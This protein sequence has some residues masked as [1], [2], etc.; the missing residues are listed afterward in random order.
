[1]KPKMNNPKHGVVL[2]ALILAVIATL[3][4]VLLPSS[5]N[6]TVSYFFCLIGIALMAG[7]FLVATAK[8]VVASFALIRQ[9][10]R[11][12]PLSLIIAAIVLVLERIKLFT[13]PAIVHVVIQV[14]LL[15]VSAISLVQTI[16]GATYIEQVEDDVTQKRTNWNI[17][18]N[19]VNMLASR[20]EDTESKA[21][22]KKVADALRYADPTSVAASQEIEQQIDTLL[23]K[24]PGA[25]CC[26]VC[27]ELLLLIQERNQIVKAQK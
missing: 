13:T 20:A 12:L 14:I 8:N 22:L 11:F 5:A 24:A 21:A 15:A 4:L 3:L 17:L 2:I 1:M 10:G 7:G 27:D 25:K 16:S 9:T 23:G 19:R 6:L 26:A 18:I